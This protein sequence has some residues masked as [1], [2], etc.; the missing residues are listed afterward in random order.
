MLK[1]SGWKVAP[2]VHGKPLTAQHC[3]AIEE[4][5]TAAGPADYALCAHGQIIGIVEAKK[6]SLG[7]QNVLVQAERYSKGLEHLGVRFGEFGVPFLYS[8]NG[9]VIWH[10]DVRHDLNR[11][12]Q[13][14]RFHTPEALSE[15]LQRDFDESLRH[16]Q[17]LPN[18]SVR[19]RPYQDPER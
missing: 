17:A 14:A 6:L 16:L 8:T 2:F 11:S 18:K 13:I 7:P 5:P 19:L 15:M 9:D 12:R 3:F 4:Y 1:A 10:H